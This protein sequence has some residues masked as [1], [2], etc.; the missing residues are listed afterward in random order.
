MKKEG[1]KV[2]VWPHHGVHFC[3]CEAASHFSFSYFPNEHLQPGDIKSQ[4]LAPKSMAW[5]SPG[6]GDSCL[7]WSPWQAARCLT[8]IVA[9]QGTVQ[10]F[11][12]QFGVL[13]LGDVRAI[14]G[15]TIT[16]DP[17]GQLLW[18]EHRA[19]LSQ[20]LK[21]TS[22]CEQWGPGAPEQVYET[23]SRG[24]LRLLEVAR[25]LHHLLP[26]L[27]PFPDRSKCNAVK[28]CREALCTQSLD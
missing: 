17:S 25:P 15:S 9:G 22:C 27:L 3:Q 26:P 21:W 1:K 28:Q 12:S 24:S 6:P 5:S 13:L 14:Q 19:L 4:F 18:A 20:T 10:A 11:W 2:P 7:S 8:A 23:L 16:T